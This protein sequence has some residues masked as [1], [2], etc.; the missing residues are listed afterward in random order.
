MHVNGWA[1]ASTARGL[2]A[3]LD[4]LKGHRHGPCRVLGHRLPLFSIGVREITITKVIAVLRRHAD[5]ECLEV[6]GIKVVTLAAL[7]V[8]LCGRQKIVVVDAHL[9]RPCQRRE[10]L[11]MGVSLEGLPRRG[12]ITWMHQKKSAQGSRFPRCQAHTVPYPTRTLRSALQCLE[13]HRGCG[14]SKQSHMA[15]ASYR[16]DIDDWS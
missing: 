3:G 2:D 12:G 13:I 16:G 11:V 6:L 14:R 9:A 8:R 1:H 10:I 7:P 5:F 4:L 15:G